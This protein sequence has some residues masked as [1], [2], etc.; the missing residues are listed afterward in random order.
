MWDFSSAII[1]PF[2]QFLRKKSNDSF[3]VRFYMYLELKI[4]RR[5]YFYFFL[6]MCSVLISLRVF[7]LIFTGLEI[8]D[9]EIL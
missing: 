4:N 7:R 5:K 9:Q 6:F 2:H 8:N 3:T 1:I